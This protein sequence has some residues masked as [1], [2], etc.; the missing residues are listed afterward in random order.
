MDVLGGGIGAS[1][2]L[3]PVEAR[4]G[5][6]PAP[7]ESIYERRSLEELPVLNAEQWIEDYQSTDNGEA[8]PG[9]FP[10]LLPN[11]TRGRAMI[12]GGPP[13]GGKTAL[14]LQWWR[15]CLEAGKNGV[16]VT[17]EMT[18]SDLLERFVR[19][20]DSEQE[21]LDWLIE[22]EAKVTQSYIQA[23]EIEALMKSGIDMLV[24]DHLHELP[25][26]DRL[27]L[28]NEVKRLLGMA[29]AHNVALLALAQLRRPDP[30]FPKPPSMHDFKE[31]GVFEQKG[32]VLL[33]IHREDEHS[34]YA[35]IWT[36]KNRF[37]S[38]HDPLSVKLNKHKVIFERAW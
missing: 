18:P 1:R 5:W 28:E 2:P 13:G 11:L 34:D 10:D 24:L 26:A 32:A 12:L 17:L 7:S 30:Q 38:K 4:R 29:P 22:H 23:P 37:G 35:Q 27:S 16:F 25:Y 21:C 14:A 20:F 36:V 9:P 31:S 3:V 6:T 33:A 15:S 19:Q 8:L